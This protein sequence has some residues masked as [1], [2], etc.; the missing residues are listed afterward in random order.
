MLTA[1]RLI[2][3]GIIG[4]ISA[5]NSSEY[6]E[7]SSREN[8][9]Q[10]A[11]EIIQENARAVAFEIDAALEMAL[12]AARTMADVLSGIKDPAVNLRMDRKR[13]NGILESIL[14]KNPSFLG[15]YTCW[16]SNAFDQLDDIYRNTTGHDGT[17]R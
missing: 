13:V 14:A 17:G 6:I 2:A 7:T 11:T 15:T 16:E 5:K 10:V 8:A 1:D 3:L 9:T 12:D 4:L